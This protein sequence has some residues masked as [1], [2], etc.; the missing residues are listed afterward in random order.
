MTDQEVYE[1]MP[2]ITITVQLVLALW[3]TVPIND[4]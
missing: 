1:K 4:L 3:Q 2:S